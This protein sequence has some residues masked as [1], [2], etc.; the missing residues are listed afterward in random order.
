M[1]DTY[2]DVKPVNWGIRNK[3]FIHFVIQGMD[4]QDAYDIAMCRFH[5][6][7]GEDL[8]WEKPSPC[9]LG[10]LKNYMPKEEE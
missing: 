5:R 6:A 8:P 1:K 9:L 2:Q 7:E 3:T 4:V 10:T